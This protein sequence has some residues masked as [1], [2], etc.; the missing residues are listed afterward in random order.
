PGQ[1]LR[2]DNALDGVSPGQ[3]ARPPPASRRRPRQRRSPERPPNLP[4][5]TGAETAGL[6]AKYSEHFTPG[7]P[8]VGKNHKL[9]P[10][11]LDRSPICFSKS[12]M[13]CGV[14]MIEGQT[15]VRHVLTVV[16]TERLGCR[17]VAS[18]GSI[19]D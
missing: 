7:C 3:P 16:L 8:A 4:P 18:C 12:F 1:S 17:L 5:P 10:Y 19:E 9:A 11:G 15:L 2:N 14:V 6:H 13:V